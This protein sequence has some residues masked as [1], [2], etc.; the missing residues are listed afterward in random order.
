VILVVS[1]PGED[2]T[3]DVMARLRAAGRRVVRLDLSDFPVTA[4]L[5][6][7]WDPAG[8]PQYR[9][10]TEQ[11]PVDLAGTRVVWWRRVRP[12]GVAPSV[13]TAL[14]RAFADSETTQAVYGML[15][16]IGC[17]WVNPREADAA[18]HHK[19]YQWSVAGRVGLTLARTLVTTRPEAARA[20]IDEVG[21]GRT[22]Y[23]AFL[24]TTEEWRETRLVE[25]QEL[26]HL[27]AVRLAPVIFQEYVPGVDLRVT[28]VGDRV[29]AAEVDARH[30]EYPVDMRMALG[31]A[32][33][34][35]AEL[36]PEVSSRLLALQRRLGLVYGA[37]DLRRTDDGRYVFLEVN[38]AGQWKFVEDRTGLPISQAVADHLAGL[39]GDG[40][41]AIRP[42][43][44]NPAKPA[45]CSSV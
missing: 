38:P 19:P 33:V 23:K 26:D 44:Q 14:H 16:G 2:H 9:V 18:A 1:Y 7:T 27:D 8:A 20:F 30:T 29:F 37:I 6:L 41:P 31:T 22:V 15:D 10:D 13:R 45:P 24:A 43:I 21:V 32:V 5:E 3:D 4:S 28:V 34:R 17:P 39:C 35:P 12:F 42:P 11:G 25:R 36:P 40:K